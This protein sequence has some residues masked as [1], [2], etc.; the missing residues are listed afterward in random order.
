MGMKPLRRILLTGDTEGGVWTFALDLSTGLIQRGLEV[1][2]VTFGTSVSDKQRESADAINGLKWAHCYSK[3]EWMPD[4]WGDLERASYF[5]VQIAR[6]WAPDLVHLNTLC[7]GDLEWNVPVV[8]THH[9]CVVS[10]WQSV[11][12]SA[13]PPDWRRYQGKVER[14]LQ[15]ATCVSAPTHWALTQAVD[16]YTLSRSAAHAVHN[17]RNFALFQ[18]AE[19]EN[20][21]F[22]AARLWDE[23]KNVSALGR[24]ARRLPWPVYLAGD[25]Q[26]PDGITTEFDNCHQ[27]GTLDTRQLACWYAKAAIY[28]LPARYEPFGLSILEA[29][30]SGC[31]L[32]LGDIPSLREL[33]SGAAIFVSH[34]D[35]ALEE[36]L[37]LLIDNSHLRQRLARRASRRA[38]E[39]TI[40]RMVD[41]YMSLYQSALARHERTTRNQ[42]CAS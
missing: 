12:G 20:I 18:T 34:E 30:L 38:R 23:G 37:R 17:G 29:A 7:H 35:G 4:P 9:S 21:V 11:K 2:L 40:S 3:L 31:A 42:A 19:K 33:W 5:L 41:G 16:N 25:A 13:L 8:T 15:S 36:A 28:A 26:G 22:S 6:T 27:L 14:S 24:T 10:W 1:C 32:V 39:F